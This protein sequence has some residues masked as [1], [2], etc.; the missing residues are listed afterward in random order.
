MQNKR[1]VLSSSKSMRISLEAVRNGEAGLNAHRQS[2]LE[3]VPKQGDWARFTLNS[4]ELKDLA[5]L[6][7][8]TGDEFAL[9]R[10]KKEDIMFH[11]DARNCCFEGNLVEL[12]INNKL[13]LEGHSHPAEEIPIASDEDRE[14][15]SIIGQKDSKIIS[16]MTGIIT[17]YGVNR[18]SVG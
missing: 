14:A 4:L 18:F 12:L 6:T 15:L 7:A 8:S 16:G 5:Y 17:E 3:R 10:G 11:G 9:L 1:I 13:Y 2:L